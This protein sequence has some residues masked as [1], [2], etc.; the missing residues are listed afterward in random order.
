MKLSVYRKITFNHRTYS[1]VMNWSSYF[2]VAK[3]TPQR[4]TYPLF[5]YIDNISSLLEITEIIT[6]DS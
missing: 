1:G 3:N 4:K 5:E 2:Y 6:N